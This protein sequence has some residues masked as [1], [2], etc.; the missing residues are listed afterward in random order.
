LTAALALADRANA[1]RAGRNLGLNEEFIS[2]Q[3]AVD[4]RDVTLRECQREFSRSDFWR[5]PMK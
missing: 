2:D 5:R 3:D 1:V 4:K